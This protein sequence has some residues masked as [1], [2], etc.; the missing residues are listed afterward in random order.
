M[1]QLGALGFASPWLLLGLIAL[2]ILWWL[3]RATPPAPLRERFPG[4]AILLGLEPPEKTPERTP[5]WL[6]LLRMAIAAL[7][8]LAFAQPLLNPREE[9]RGEGPVRLVIDDGWASAADWDARMAAAEEIVD[10]ADRA[11]RGVQIETLAAPLDDARLAEVLGAAEA[12]AR[13]E[14]LSPVPWPPRRAELSARLP[15]LG[16]GETVWLH[17]GLD[18]DGAF[19]D[20]AGAL[21]EGGGLRLIGPESVVQAVIPAGPGAEGL[22]AQALRI[23]A[24][25]E[26]TTQIIGYSAEENGTRRAL[27]V[28][29]AAFGPDEANALATFDVPLELRNR[30][31]AFGLEGA[32]HA[33]A[34]ALIDSRW[35]RQRVGLV[36]GER[37]EGNQRLLSGS[38][39]LRNALEDRAELR[40]GPIA[41]L[42]EAQIDALVL[43]D[44]G[45]FPDEEAAALRTWVEAGGLLVRFAGPA[46]AATAEERRFDFNAAS[47]PLLPVRLRPGGRDL[48]GA[49]SWGE[50]QRIA[51]FP[52]T[53]PF[54]GLPQ[55]EDARISKQ[56]LAE[57]DIDLP[58]R[59]WASLT[60]GAPM[61]TSEQVGE[62]RIVLFHTTADPRWSTL[63]LSGLFIEML[64]RIVKFGTGGDGGQSE[65]TGFWAPVSLIAADGR[66][67]PASDAAAS[68]DGAL[69]GIGASVDA[70][71]GVYRAVGGVGEGAIR[72][73]NLLPEEASLTAAPPAPEG[74]IVETLGVQRETSLKPLLLALALALFA[75]DAI[76]AF[77]LA[78]KL[79]GAVAAAVLLGFASMAA[80]QPA[81]AQSEKSD[82]QAI[83]AALDGAL[84]FVITGDAKNDEIARAGLFGL[85]RAMIERTSVEPADPVG[86]NLEADELSVYPMIYWAVSEKQPRPSSEAMA[87]LNEFMRRGGMLVIDT[88]DQNL[89]LGGDTPGTRAL[90]RLTAGL[91]LPPLSP[92]PEGHVLHRSFFLLDEFPGRWRGGD[93][94]VEASP[95]EDIAEAA[96]SGGFKNDGVTP[97]VVGGADWAGAW[98]ID[99]QG[100]PLLPVA[101]RSGSRQREMA[102]RF[103]VNLVM[104]AYTGSYKSDQVHIPALLQRLGQ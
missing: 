95:P 90:R 13:L 45:S 34:V 2:P 64:D 93:V 83:R 87:K 57:P 102:Y 91:D 101:G 20:L 51:P 44:V 92:V 12:R 3:L 65:S 25:T 59:T 5:W 55:P 80:P 8:I 22:S 89:A 86:V 48:G 58:A 62:G 31:A 72:A 16:E 77:A 42:L 67:L 41:D 82:E 4:V 73:H 78:G 60:D 19:G 43:V 68:V 33:G 97:I 54:F 63:P 70:P 39:Y 61:V 88:R 36:S 85:T 27:A 10:R 23:A 15:E 81:F 40:E 46:L 17:D 75:I 52:E 103:G 11:G 53:S 76:A 79:R 69:L 37:P 35:R 56:V 6:L 14:A 1:M 71:P 24:E 50:P 49:M 98:A 74:A 100:R 28:A 104:Y 94:W 29:E 99:E 66:L 7:A 26:G 47:D 21:L 18:H 30:I 9:L 38:H 96:E 84:G 32:D